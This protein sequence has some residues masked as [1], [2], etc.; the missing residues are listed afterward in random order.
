MAV[1]SKIQN[2]IANG[3]NNFFVNVASKI[4]ETFNFDKL[5]QFC[6]EKIQ[7]TPLF[8]TRNIL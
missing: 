5:R 3:F 6:N 7:L 2:N 4:K 8:N 1:L